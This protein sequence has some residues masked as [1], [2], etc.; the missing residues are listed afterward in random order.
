M[1]KAEWDNYNNRECK[2]EPRNI[3]LYY[4]FNIKDIK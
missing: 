2:E 1:R 3:P 4:C